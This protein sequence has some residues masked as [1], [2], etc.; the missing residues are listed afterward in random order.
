P[1][2]NATGVSLYVAGMMVTAFAIRGLEVM[3]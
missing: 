1:W 3:P 2:Y